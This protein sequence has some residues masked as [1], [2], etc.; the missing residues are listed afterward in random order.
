MK[1]NTHIIDDLVEAL[2]INE[3]GLKTL[4]IES[5]PSEQFK[6]QLEFY[7]NAEPEKDIEKGV[8]IKDER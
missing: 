1:L 6:V 8:E 4:H 7:I 5:T 2:K 3:A